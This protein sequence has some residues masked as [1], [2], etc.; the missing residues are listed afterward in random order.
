MNLKTRIELLIL[1]FGVAGFI[2]YAMA[3]MSAIGF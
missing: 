1:F 2:A 3:Y